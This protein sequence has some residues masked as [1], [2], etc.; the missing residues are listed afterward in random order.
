M[1]I[2][3]NILDRDFVKLFIALLNLN[4]NKQICKVMERRGKI[5]TLCNNRFLVCK[6]R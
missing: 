2:G 4:L 5:I 3:P 6:T 1:I